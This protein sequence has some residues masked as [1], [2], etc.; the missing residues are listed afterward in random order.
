[1]IFILYFRCKHVKVNA[2]LLAVGKRNCNHS[3]SITRYCIVQI[4]AAQRNQVQVIFVN[5]AIKE[6][7]QN[8]VGIGKTLVNIIARVTSVELVHT[9][10]QEEIAFR[11]SLWLIIKLNTGIDTAGAADKDLALILRVQ[12][13]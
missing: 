1:M 11:N 10:A 9:H 5:S 4:T 2:N 6:T 8:L 12:V 3:H 7:R 13:D